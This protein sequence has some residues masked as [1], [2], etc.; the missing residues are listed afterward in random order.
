MSDY[1]NR[2][3]MARLH[4]NSERRQIARRKQSSITDKLKPKDLRKLNFFYGSKIPVEQIQTNL[5]QIC[6]ASLWP[7]LN[8]NTHWQWKSDDNQILQE[9]KVIQTITEKQRFKGNKPLRIIC[10]A[11]KEGLGAVLQRKSEEGWQAI[12]LHHAFQPPLNKSNL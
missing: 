8:K 7:L 3:R 12:V 5:A 1:E 10:D 4:T 2:N 6:G 9:M 11:S